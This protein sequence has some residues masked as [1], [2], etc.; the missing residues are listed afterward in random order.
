MKRWSILA[1]ILMVIGMLFSFTLAGQVHPNGRSM[2]AK[3]FQGSSPGIQTDLMRI[4]S[5]AI[6]QPTGGGKYHAPDQVQ[7]E[8]N[9]EQARANN[10]TLRRVLASIIVGLFNLALWAALERLR[11]NPPKRIYL[12]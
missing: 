8:Q 3:L 6:Y 12:L 7:A 1:A 2:E 4:T 11:H 10:L 5:K 9:A